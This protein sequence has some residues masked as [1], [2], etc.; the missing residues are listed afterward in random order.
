MHRKVRAPEELQE[1]STHLRYEVTML[2]TLANGIASGVAGQGAIA[3]ALLESFVT[4]VR[5]SIDFLY[6]DNPKPDDVIAEDFF[7]APEQWKQHRPALSQALLQ[8]KRRAGKEVAHLTYARLA[9]A[10]EAK[11]WPFM[12]I[13]REVADLIKLFVEHVPLGNLSSEWKQPYEPPRKTN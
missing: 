5:N 2:T 4:H 3:N 6:A 12:Q 11:P 13:A 1:A 8:A 10:P 7:G 9:V